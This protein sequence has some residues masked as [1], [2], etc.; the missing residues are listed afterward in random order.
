[1]YFR[2]DISRQEDLLPA[3]IAGLARSSRLEN[4]ASRD[5]PYTRTQALLGKMQEQRGGNITR[6]GV[7]SE[8]FSMQ[9]PLP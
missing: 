3:D 6:D 2:S 7:E 8:Y 9:R 1:M 5:T 4:E